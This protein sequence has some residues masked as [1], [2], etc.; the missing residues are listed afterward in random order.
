MRLGL[1]RL[2]AVWRGE[3]RRGRHGAMRLGLAGLGPAHGRR[4]SSRLDMAWQGMVRLAWQAPARR[5][6]GWRGLVSLNL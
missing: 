6:A 2:G 4:G 5:G 1:A 3:A